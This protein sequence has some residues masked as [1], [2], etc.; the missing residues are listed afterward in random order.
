MKIDV[1][2]PSER[3]VSSSWDLEQYSSAN[4]KYRHERYLRS[5][6]PPQAFRSG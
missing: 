4:Q 5:S 2:I 1:P 6:I 3:N